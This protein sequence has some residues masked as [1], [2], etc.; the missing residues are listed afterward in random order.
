MNDKKTTATK[1][2]ETA[3]E[4]Y[5]FVKRQYAKAREASAKGAPVAWA[6]GG[7]L[8]EDMLYAMD[9]VPLYPE[10]Y[11]GVCAAKKLAGPLLTTAEA[12]GYSSR[13]CG[14]VRTG[15]GHAIKRQ[16]LGMIP[17]DMP[18]GGMADPVMLIGLSAACDPRYK[19]FQT[20]ARYMDVPYIMYDT[21][22]YVQCSTDPD[23]VK[24]YVIAYLIEE[25]RRLKGFLEKTLGRRMDDA[26]L[27]EVVITAEETRNLWWKCDMIRRAVPCPMPTADM[28]T[29]FV[30]GLFYA[31]DPESL[32]F[33]KK[34]YAE[35]EHRVQNKMGV[36]PDEK[37]RLLW[38]WGLPPWHSMNI[39][40]HFLERGA[41]FVMETCYTPWGP[42]EEGYKYNDPIERMARGRFHRFNFKMKAA[43]RNRVNRDAQYVIDF[44]DEFRCDGLVQHQVISCPARSIGQ[45]TSK[46]MLK[47]FVDVPVLFM[48]GDIVDETNYSEVQTKAQ[49]DVFIEIMDSHK[50]K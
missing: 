36:I 10:N 30:P 4:S 27:M 6:M 38:G 37:Y 21:L 41:V 48:E 28:L 8:V 39:F 45:K 3:K 22:D 31:A 44:I 33:Y 26:R 18:E 2:T 16:R 23:E 35:L 9:V 40:N 43:H 14:Y 32:E 5:K 19:W 7:Q 29:C 1:S 50:R 24:E 49:I 13:L 42:F 12:E 46:D 11:G 17:P 20:L 34:L 15:I 25:L 47:N